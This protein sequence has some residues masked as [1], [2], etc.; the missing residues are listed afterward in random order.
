MNAP[1]SLRVEE[2]SIDRERP[3][4]VDALHRFLTLHLTSEENEAL[5]TWRYRQGPH[6]V[7]RVWTARGPRG[8]V[9]GVATAF[10]RRMRVHRDE[11]MGWVLGDF[12]IHPDHRSLGPAVRL[13]RV[14][15]EEA[16]AGK[17][18]FWY[19]YPNPGMVAVHRRLGLEPTH[20]LARFARPL[21]L[22]PKLRAIVRSRRL[23]SVLAAPANWMLGAG[24][25]ASADGVE[26]A[27]QSGPC[28]EEFTDVS[29]QSLDGLG[30]ATDRTA[31]YLNWRYLEDPLHRHEI[32]TAR[33]GG[34]LE[35][36]AVFEISETPA[37]ARV[38][39]LVG[40]DGSPVVPAL[41][42]ALLRRLR[43]TGVATVSVPIL[44]T[45]RWVPHLVRHGFR[46][47]ESTPVVTG[48]SPDS[49][50]RTHL[51]GGGSWHLL[52]GDRDV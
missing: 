46:R 36:Y 25:T 7:P 13:Q 35:G 6:G 4:L 33:R 31:E 41:L 29:R 45:H 17:L 40:E 1:A 3:A 34:A 14:F 51:G 9:I 52:D 5:F 8:D 26:F 38:L 11:E 37:R 30:L 24:G 18:R 16:R 27:I 15:L 19:D 50:S 43:A 23:A 2:V 47:R 28:G 21:R 20:S 44:S 10:P 49:R 12:C 48:G 39:D 22:D 32:L 42:G